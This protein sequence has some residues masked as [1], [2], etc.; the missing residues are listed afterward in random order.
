[1]KW[2]MRLDSGGGILLKKETRSA[3]VPAQP[4]ER[5]AFS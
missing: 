5:T 3:G 2:E 4:A 1:M